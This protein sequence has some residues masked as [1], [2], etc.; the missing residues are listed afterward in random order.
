MHPRLGAP[1]PDSQPGDELSLPDRSESN[2]ARPLSTGS[3]CPHVGL[4]LDPETQYG[5][6]SNGNHCHRVSPPASI[7]FLHQQIYCLHTNHTSC[8]V[9]QQTW[10]GILP[11]G[12]VVTPAGPSPRR[13]S[14]YLVLAVL[15]LLLAAAIALPIV[16]QWLQS[17][18]MNQPGASQ[19]TTAVLPASISPA[20]SQASSNEPSNT[21]LISTG[22]EAVGNLIPSQTSTLQPTSTATLA[23]TPTAA[24]PT[25][26]PGLETPFGQSG[27]YL[28]HLVR[29]GESWGGIANKYSTTVELLLYLNPLPPGM[30]LWANKILVVSPGKTDITTVRP[31]QVMVLEQDASVS[32]LASKYGLPENDFRSLNSLGP[33]DFIL[34]GRY[35]I[36][37]VG[38]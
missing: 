18:F 4:P 13:R 14:L 32:N 37:P 31:M 33:A 2:A 1:E 35:L 29:A 8:P 38:Q 10:N 3:L 15:F 27:S 25:P 36:L 21:H 24:P 28:L 22:K 23:L 11:D 12:L 7:D 20:P 19:F 34:A 5:F 30:G 9:F 6:P 26:G 16:T 17:I